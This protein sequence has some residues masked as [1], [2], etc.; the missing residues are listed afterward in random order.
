MGESFLIYSYWTSL[1]P[2]PSCDYST[3][4]NISM[5]RDWANHLWNLRQPN[6]NM[7][8]INQLSISPV[9]DI[10]RIQQNLLHKNKGNKR[11]QIRI[12]IYCYFWH[13]IL[14]MQWDQKLIYFN[15]MK[16]EFLPED[17]YF[18]KYIFFIIIGFNPKKGRKICV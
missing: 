7:N 14:N 2:H 12:I 10:L 5:L 8:L 3:M 6:S 16:D 13:N 1:S 11:L 17:V 15:D 4:S 18:T 9:D